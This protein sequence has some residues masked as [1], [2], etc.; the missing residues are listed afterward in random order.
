MRVS[1]VINPIFK[2]RDWAVF[3][4]SPRDIE[5]GT[6]V[7]GIHMTCKNKYGTEY[8][9]DPNE[10]DNVSWLAGERPICW[11]CQFKVPDPIQVLMVLHEWNNPDD[12]PARMG[13]K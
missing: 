5:Q 8:L 11:N 7:Y 12:A 2:Y 1:A 10:N 9:E 3:R 13:Y 6:G 4:A